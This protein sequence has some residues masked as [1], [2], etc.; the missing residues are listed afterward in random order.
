MTII[1]RRVTMH[2]VAP[3]VCDVDC[4]LIYETTNPL[5]VSIAFYPYGYTSIY[6]KNIIQWTFAR[7]LLV[8]GLIAC[9]GRGDVRVQPSLLR[10]N[11]VVIAFT[12]ITDNQQSEMIMTISRQIVIRF[13]CR[14]FIEVPYED[15]TSLIMSIVD[16]LLPQFHKD[17]Q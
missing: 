4:K 15:E 14:T 8:N 17:A 16:N 3:D 7:D 11:M 2:M 1:E 5:A 13:L 6:D 12:G 10:D 9:T